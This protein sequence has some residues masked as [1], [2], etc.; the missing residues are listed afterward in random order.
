MII[1]TTSVTAGA[2]MIVIRVMSINWLDPAD[3]STSRYNV[4]SLF[5]EYID[6]LPGICIWAY[7][8]LFA[9]AVAVAVAA[10]AAASA[11]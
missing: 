5:D 3:Q 7:L 9:V 10:A 11:G 8:C 4:C 1:I 6:I 2:N